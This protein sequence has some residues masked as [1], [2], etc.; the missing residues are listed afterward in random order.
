L[1][2]LGLVPPWAVMDTD[3]EHPVLVLVTVCRPHLKVVKRWLRASQ[4]PED[5]VVVAATQYVM[6][7]YQKVVGDLEVEVF[8]PVAV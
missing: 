8:A 2:V 3:D 4:L 1:S 7:N 6:D 5:D